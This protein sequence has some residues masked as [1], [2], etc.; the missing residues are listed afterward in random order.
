GTGTLLQLLDT[1]YALNI[2]SSK[3]N[4][5]IRRFVQLLREENNDVTRGKKD[6]ILRV[7]KLM[8]LIYA[9]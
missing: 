9:R 4:E 2:F 6:H 5:A 7:K 8:V 1:E 3:S